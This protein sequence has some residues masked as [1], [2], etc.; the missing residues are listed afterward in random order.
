MS[1][2]PL[3]KT[4]NGAHWPDGRQVFFSFGDTT[5][6]VCGACVSSLD[7]D[8]PCD[9]C[10]GEGWVDREDLD[11][12]ERSSEIVTCPECHGDPARY[13]C[14]TCH[15]SWSLAELRAAGLTDE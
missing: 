2:K 6:P 3:T 9:E 14:P 13:R 8:E 1:D 10:D 4:D 5:H 11:D 7:R 15:V 12:I